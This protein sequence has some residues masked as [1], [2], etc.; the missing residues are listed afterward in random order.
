[1]SSP[2]NA[3]TVASTRRRTSSGTETS[4]GVA[5]TR[6]SSPASSASSCLARRSRSALRAHNMT[7]APSSQKAGAPANPTP[8]PEPEIRAR[9]PANFMVRARRSCPA[10]QQPGGLLEEAE[11]AHHALP[12]AE[13]RH[14]AQ[15]PDPRAIEKDERAVAGPASVTAGV[16]PLGRHAEILADPADGLIHL[17]VLVRAEVEDV[18]F[19]FRLRERQQDRVDAVVNVEIGLPLLAVAEDAQ[20]HRVVTQLPEEVEDVPVGVALSEDR[21]EAEDV[22]LEPEALTI[23]LDQAFRRE[24]GGAVEGGLDGQGS[25]LRR[26]EDLRLPVN[27][28]RG[29]EGDAPD[30]MGA[31]RLQHVERRDRVLLQVLPRVFPAVADVGVR[32]KVKHDIGAPHRPGQRLL[33]EGVAAHQGEARGPGRL[34]QEFGLAG[35]EIVVADHLVTVLEQT[36][37]EAASDETRGPGHKVGHVA[38]VPLLRAGPERGS[39]AL[40]VHLAVDDE[41]RA[42]LHLVVD[43]SDVLTDQPERQQLDA[44]EER[45]LEDGGGQSRRQV[46]ADE[47]LNHVPRAEEEAE[48]RDQGPGER[49]ELERPAAETDQPVEADLERPDEGVV[50]APPMDP[51]VTLVLH[52]GLAQPDLGDQ[53][54]EE[55][56]LLIQPAELLD[57]PAGHDA[58]VAR[59]PRDLD[60]AEPRDHPV[61]DLGDRALDRGLSLAGPALGVD[62]FVALAEPDR[63]STRLNSSHG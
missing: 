22:P 56:V 41:H 47:L 36:I 23:G 42:P 62:D 9:L 63:K 21:H 18:D 4:A 13:G 50:V 53:S 5:S 1:M 26:R 27:R 17:T 12:D 24:L 25:L 46:H 58:E 28:T 37:D 44:R 39:P 52:E 57:H 11:G 33:V 43:P 35:G 8:R 14:P 29:G 32:G 3:V 6:D 55:P 30:P 7:C 19:A 51:L 2:P 60:L 40:K 10:L 16:H 54:A 38:M 48:P 49:H 45:D 31:H 34:G 61:T 20:M 59:V 15:R